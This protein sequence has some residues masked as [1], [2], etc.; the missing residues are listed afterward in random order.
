MKDFV[1]KDDNSCKP[2]KFADQIT[3]DYSIMGPNEES[4]HHHRA[5]LIV[6]DNSPCK[7]LMAYP[8]RSNNSGHTQHSMSHFCGPGVVPK[9]VYTDGGQEFGSAFAKL[10]WPPQTS[11]PHRPQTNGIA[12]RSVERVNQGTS[13]QISQSGLDC[14]YW[15]ESSQTY[16]MLRNISEPVLGTQTPYTADL[17]AQHIKELIQAE[18]EMS[19]IAI[20]Q[21]RTLNFDTI[22]SD[23][24]GTTYDKTKYTK[25]TNSSTT[26]PSA[27]ERLLNKLNKK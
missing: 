1:F 17:K 10:G 11:T 13:C 27:S 3:A 16:C 6:Q 25:K 2:E 23:I 4:R 24:F 18:N 26:I 15:S 12:E 22:E 19:R 8:G 9:M 21:L 5:N 20:V 7:W 14:D